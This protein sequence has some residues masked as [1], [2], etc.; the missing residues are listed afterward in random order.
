MMARRGNPI[1][2]PTWHENAVNGVLQSRS[3]FI[4]NVHAKF[5]R[6]G[7][8]GRAS[9]E[10]RPMSFLKRT[11]TVVCAEDI[12]MAERLRAVSCRGRSKRQSTRVGSPSEPIRPRRRRPSTVED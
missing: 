4:K 9:G 1:V 5:V 6:L 11:L 10:A 3:N 7:K 8:G 12:A 2:N